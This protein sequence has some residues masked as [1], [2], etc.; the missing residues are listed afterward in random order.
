MSYET[1][2]LPFIVFPLFFLGSIKDSVRMGVVH[3]LFCGGTIAAI[4][5]I[6]L[7]LNDARAG[8][9]LSDTHEVV[10]R[11]FSSLWIGPLTDLACFKRA[12]AHV[13]SSHDLFGFALV[14]FLILSLLF[15]FRDDPDDPQKSQEITRLRRNLLMVRLGLGGLTA[16]SFSYALTLYWKAVLPV[17]GVSTRLGSR[18]FHFPLG[19]SNSIREKGS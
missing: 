7:R 18:A 8:R 1:A 3:L 10:A 15:L 11:I 14:L 2:Y 13:F 19:P 6:R 17:C 16:W 5:F 12:F 9:V 4:M